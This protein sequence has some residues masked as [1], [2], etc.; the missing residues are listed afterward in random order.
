MISLGTSEFDF[1]I[2]EIGIRVW[3]F[4][5]SLVLLG[6]NTLIIFSSVPPNEENLSDQPITLISIFKQDWRLKINVP[7]EREATDEPTDHSKLVLYLWHNNNYV[8]R[9][10][11]NMLPKKKK[12]IGSIFRVLFQKRKKKL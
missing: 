11:L 4:V 6:Q 7:T 8:N 3:L 2:N 9:A 5:S 10:V 1:S 12:K